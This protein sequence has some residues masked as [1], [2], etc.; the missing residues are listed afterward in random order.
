[1]RSSVTHS[2]RLASILAGLLPALVSAQSSPAEGEALQLDKLTITGSNIAG[3]DT[4]K[5]LPITV[6]TSEDFKEAGFTSMAQF[7]EA[8]PFSTN[9][10]IND[11]ETGPN[12]ARGDVATVNLRNLGAGRTL[13][14][15][16]GRRM[17]AYGITPG[18]PPVQF[19][20]INAIPFGAIRQVEVLRDGASAIYGSDAIGGVVNTILRNSYDGYEVNARYLKDE[21]SLREY[22][23]D[24]GG[25][26]DF[27]GG[28]SNLSIFFNYF[29]RT[30]LT[31]NDRD[32][33]RDADKRNLVPEPFNTV[34]A[35]NRRSSS[36]P[37]GR[38]TALT[39]TGSSASVPGVT[40][41]NGQFYYD[42]VTGAR[43]TGAGPTATYNFQPNT[44]LIP[45]ARRYNLFSALTH[46]INKQLT[47]FGELSYYE[48][49]SSGFT[50]SI[51]ISSGTD[52]VVIPKTNYYSPVGTNSGV[53]TPRNVSIRNYRVMDAGL[54][55]YSTDADSYR[56]LAGLR[57]S[58][59]WDTWTWESGLMHMRGHTYQENGGHISQS[60]FLAQ[61]ALATP[62]AYNP[63]G[64]PGSN[65][66]SVTD[67]FVISI[68]DDG[69]GSLTSFDAKASGEIYKLSGG[70]V[71]LA[72]G[73]E[74]R[75]E[76]M[77]Q[78]ND[79]YGLADDV[80]AQSEQIDVTAS[81]KV[82]AG[83]SEVRF[84]LIGRD[85][86]LPIAESL[87]LTAAGRYESY[88]GFSSFKPGTSA[89]WRPLSWVMIRASYNEGFRA[90][91]IVELYT[92]AIGRRNEGFTDP[93]R[94]GQPDA[95]SNIT[96]RVVTGGNPDLKPEESESQNIGIVVDVPGLKGLTLTADIYRIKQFNQIDN[97][98][99]ANELEVDA[100][101]WAA[102]GGSNPLVIRAAR[103]P[104]DITAG[105][106]GVLVEVISTYQNRSLREL[107]GFDAGVQ[108]R[109]PATRFGRF[110]LGS[111]FSYTSTLFTVDEKGVR[112]NLLR[113]L[114]NPRIK[115]TG[116][117]SW[118]HKGWSA[119]VSERFTDDYLAS[120]TYSANGRR[121][122]VEPYWVMNANV[123]Y[124]F[125]KGALKGLKVRVG[126]NNV[127]NE[128]P[129]FYPASSSGYNSDYSDARGRTTYVDLT[130]RF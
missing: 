49:R 1:M 75:S 4:E 18:T 114:G 66:K 9:L 6:M 107:H 90:P 87:E 51:P 34:S 2:F 10:S 43:A 48:S 89:A 95:A 37:Y 35:Y 92:P 93:A 111:L 121:F 65:P 130:Y 74:Y 17:S 12:G 102:N 54:R 26:Y 122:V 58:L 68:W 101:L 81:R 23:V 30:G 47:F 31:A 67:K 52:G 16:N 42:P 33:A 86:R 104:A 14:L 118:S 40:A 32:Y 20:N 91:S 77:E 112:S 53:T 98:S 36:G 59:P 109:I 72:L 127:E 84:P 46:R 28:K 39:D 103:T 71:S 106:P 11:S 129:P 24:I 70:A 62:D 63:F 7:I 57:G 64:V 79:P 50:D 124:S 82:Y 41:T 19:V 15:L 27:N 126:M 78:R 123:G 25:G 108:Y 38:F 96:K 13:V 116:S 110:T 117:I 85:N 105:I 119:S 113:S 73:G 3:I 88:K 125:K 55:T 56:V 5:S 97:T 80:I 83:F 29:D 44:T 128:D 99:A 22:N 69:V 115:A 100:A 61:L 60:K 45:D 8:L 94:P 120:T 21:T 76:K